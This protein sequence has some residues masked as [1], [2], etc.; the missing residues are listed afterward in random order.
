MILV[1]T[2]EDFMCF[3]AQNISSIMVMEFRKLSSELTFE[4]IYLCPEALPKRF[5]V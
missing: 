4:K 1:L 5:D 2:F 3:G